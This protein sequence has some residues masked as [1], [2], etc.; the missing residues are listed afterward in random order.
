MAEININVEVESYFILERLKDRAQYKLSEA[1]ESLIKVKDE[2][3]M[4]LRRLFGNFAAKDPSATE[5]LANQKFEE[6]KR[7]DKYKIAREPVDHYEE[8]ISKIDK[9]LL[10][11]E[12]S[13][14]ENL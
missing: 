2:Y 10:D 14:I 1:Q 11:I 8:L 4:E 13:L 3:A 9:K 5:R 7:T 12:N 6:F